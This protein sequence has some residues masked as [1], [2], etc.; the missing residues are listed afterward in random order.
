MVR[1]RVP[2]GEKSRVLVPVPLDAFV[3]GPAAHA[4]Y[5]LLAGGVD[6]HNDDRIG[7]VKGRKELVE[8]VLRPRIPVR[9]E[10]RNHLAAGS[11]LCSGERGPDLRR[12]MAV[13]V[14]NR[15]P[16]DLA[17]DLEA[18]LHAAETPERRTDYLD[19]DIELSRHG[20]CGETVI[21]IVHPGDGKLEPAEVPAVVRD[22][23]PRAERSERNVLRLIVGLGTHAVRQIPLLNKR[24]E[25]LNMLFV[26]AEY[27]DAVERDLVDEHEERILDLVDVLVVVEV[28]RVDV[29]HHGDGRR[30]FE[31]APVA[32]IGFGNEELALPELG[33]RAKAVQLAA[34]DDRGVYVACRKNRG[35]HRGGGRLAVRAGN[36]HPVLEPHELREHF[37]AG[38]HRYLFLLGG[39]HL[40]IVFFHSR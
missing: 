38:D 40:N 18:A 5:G 2:V 7:L 24:D 37:R 1:D 35:H 23:E 19:V 32:L 3:D 4:G 36:G 16:V 30:K 6:V 33:V 9:L 14:D 17:L 39:Y 21:D 13:I 10:H 29:R 11:G 22:L 15:D 8:K 20:D 12:V 34:D 28:F 27:G 31:K 26:E 25:R